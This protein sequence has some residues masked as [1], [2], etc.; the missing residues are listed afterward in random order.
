MSPLLEVR[1]LRTRFRVRKGHIY[2]VNGVSFAV[3]EGETLGIVGESGCGKSVTMLSLMRLLPRAAEIEGGQA[4][5]EGA[6]LLRMRPG[7]LQHVR[8]GRIGMIFQDPM[9]SLNPVVNI[10]TQLAE[11]LIYHKGMTSNQARARCVDLLKSV[12]IQDAEQILR[13]FQHQLSGGMRQRVM[14]AMATACEPRLVIADEPTTALDVTIQAQIIDLVKALRS[15]LSASIIWITHDLG[16]T[17]SLADRIIVMY[18]GHVVEEASVD[19]L[20]EDPRHPYTLGLIRAVPSM[21]DSPDRRLSTISGAPP[22]LTLRPDFCPFFPRCPY[23]I[24]K[25]QEVRPPLVPA[26]GSPSSNHSFACWIDVRE[27]GVA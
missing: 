2:A 4:L 7:D 14:I 25:C 11:P 13:E 15:Q 23:R 1:D 19:E 16:V 3:N 22:D 24:P 26:Q 9:T 6:D 17:A 10:G 12:G 5:F 21:T 18:A 20:Y 8:G 27:K